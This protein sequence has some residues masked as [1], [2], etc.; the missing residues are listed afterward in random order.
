MIPGFLEC[1]RVAGSAQICQETEFLALAEA[2]EKQP[3]SV[4]QVAVN[5][6]F[7]QCGKALIRS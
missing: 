2:Q 7:L 4:I 3:M 5:E 1:V 6:A